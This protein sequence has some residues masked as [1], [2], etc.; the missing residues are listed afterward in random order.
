MQAETSQDQLRCRGFRG[1]WRGTEGG[2]QRQPRTKR[3][4]MPCTSLLT[5]ISLQQCPQEDGAWTGEAPGQPRGSC[6]RNGTWWHLFTLV[7]ASNLWPYQRWPSSQAG[8]LIPGN[9][10][11]QHSRGLGGTRGDGRVCLQQG[12]KGPQAAKL[13]LSLP[14]TRRAKNHSHNN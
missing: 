13:L 8:F 3:A 14:S 2:G 7:P 11:V 5:Q 4:G 10:Y 9:R 1:K 12:H 6:L